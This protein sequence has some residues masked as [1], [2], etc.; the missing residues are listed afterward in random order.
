MPYIPAI[1]V[2]ITLLIIEIVLHISEILV[3]LNLINI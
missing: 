2:I 3:D 1:K